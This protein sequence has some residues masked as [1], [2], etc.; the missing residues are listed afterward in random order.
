MEWFNKSF[1]EHTVIWL[2]IS[3]IAGGAIGASIK[4]LF[5]NI[6]TERINAKRSATQAIKKYTYPLLRSGESLNRYIE[7]LLHN[8]NKNWFDDKVDNYFRLAILYQFANFFGWIKILEDEAFLEFEATKK[9]V[10][11]FN[12]HFYSVQESL[13]GFKYFDSGMKEGIWNST[14]IENNTLRNMIISAI[15][16]IMIVNEKDKEK[17]P[18]T[19]LE[20]NKLYAKTENK[21]WFLYLEKFLT[22][23][24]PDNAKDIRINRLITFSIN[25][26][27]LLYFLDPKGQ[28][29]KTKEV[30][31]FSMLHFS[32]LEKMLLEME[33]DTHLNFDL[34][35]N[36]IFFQLQ[37]F[38]IIQNRAATY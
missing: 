2:L 28:Y 8:I 37:Q 7:L 12:S 17:R 14:E 31:Y 22:D 35:S 4:L 34:I 33:N 38:K 18:A 36:N 3:T 25:Q 11:K 6:L 30:N 13:N 10:R 5:E 32:I 27:L 23:I 24:K 26:R 16:E 21:K 1:E 20:F 9:N 15:G 19:F 29:T